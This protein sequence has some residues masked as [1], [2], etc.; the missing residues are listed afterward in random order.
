MVFRGKLHRQLE[1]GLTLINTKGIGMKA[2]EINASV[3][4]AQPT[5]KSMYMAE[6][7]RGNPAPK[8]DLMKSLPAST[9]AAYSG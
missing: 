6:A 8:A 9:D 7:K 5:P 4:L 2:M 1:K 3:E